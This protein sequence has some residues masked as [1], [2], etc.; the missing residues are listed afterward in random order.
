[1]ATSPPHE[2][3]TAAEAAAQYERACDLALWRGEVGINRVRLTMVVLGAVVLLASGSSN[4]PSA[5]LVLWAQDLLWAAWAAIVYVV[6]RRNP[7]RSP[8]WLAPASIAVDQVVL[9]A[10]YVAASRNVGGVVEY[11][12]GGVLELFAVSNIL[13]GLRLSPWLCV[14]GGGASALINAALL[15]WSVQT[16]AVVTS[17]VSSYGS[18]SLHVPDVVLSIFVAS[19]PG[20]GMALVARVSRSLVLRAEMET[21]AR[22]AD[23]QEYQR[24]AKYLPRQVVEVMMRDPARRQLGGQRRTATIVFVDLRNFTAMSE[25]LQPEQTVAVLNQ[26]F[27][28]MV[29]RL[30]AYEGTLDKFL[31]DGFMA[32]F[33][34]PMEVDRA[35]TR[36]VVAAI[37]MVL[38]MRQLSDAVAQAGTPL[39]I[40]VGIATGEVLSGTIGSP[41]RMEFTCIGPPVNLASRLE[42]LNKRLGTHI[43]LDAE[44]ARRLDPAIV[45]TDKGAVPVR[46]LTGETHVAGVDVDAQRPADLEHLRL[47]LY[48]GGER[49]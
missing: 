30:F 40:G 32:V 16:G 31:G 9:A 20:F 28:A 37:D 48:G 36:A 38:A 25:R 45:T 11:W 14:L 5:N 7:E 23:R 29:E 43:L 27:A 21:A 35:P 39:A 42:G 17:A 19:L 33:G 34:A 26:F 49:G 12:Q 1:M 47:S 15:A 10:T 22:A 46:G 44:T 2:L 4:T 6:L 8:R 41:D 3:T 24:L 18:G 13:T